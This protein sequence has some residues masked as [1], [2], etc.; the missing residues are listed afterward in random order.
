VTAYHVALFIL[1][2]YV[3]GAPYM[4]SHMVT[5]ST[6]LYSKQC[7]HYVIARSTS[8]TVRRILQRKAML[9]ESSVSKR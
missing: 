9:V 7:L 1:A 6:E 2:T 8:I 3:P 5:V 4:Y